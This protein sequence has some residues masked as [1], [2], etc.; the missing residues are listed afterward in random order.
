MK[1]IEHT[2][3]DL[4]AVQHEA[5]LMLSLQTPHILRAYYYATC[6]QQQDSQAKTQHNRKGGL[7]TRYSVDRTPSP[8]GRLAATS[9]DSSSGRMLEVLG[10]TAV[11]TTA[12][13]GKS[14]EKLAA[15]TPTA[16]ASTW[17]SKAGCSRTSLDITD[18]EAGAVLVVGEETEDVQQLQLPQRASCELVETA[19]AAAEPTAQRAETHLVLE[20]CDAGTLGAVTAEWA[21]EAGG[22]DE[23]ML[24]RLV[25][26]KDVAAGLEV[27]HNQRVVHADL[28]GSYC[29][30]LAV[31]IIACSLFVAHMLVRQYCRPAT[32]A[33][34]LPGCCML[35][36]TQPSV[37]RLASF[38]FNSSTSQAP[39]TAATL[40]L[41]L[42]SR[43]FHFRMPAMCL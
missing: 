31:A 16:L 39:A 8:D 33:S 34:G 11:A 18:L 6:V 26:L 9:I 27:L 2:T 35:L 43:F 32:V 21:P 30:P 20:Y 25:L 13:A 22:L 15:A 41:P 4:A 7:G 17:S 3:K 23:H 40:L 29:G 24:E 10:L 37:S 42:P 28:V 5:E 36:A 38:S 19:A 1:I 14:A 12:T